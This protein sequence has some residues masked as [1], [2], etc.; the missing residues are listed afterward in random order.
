MKILEIRG[1]NAFGLKEFD[2]TPNGKSVIFK[3]RNGA[4]K[5]SL[6]KSIEACVGGTKDELKNISYLKGD[7]D[8]T[9]LLLVLGETDVREWELERSYDSEGRA[10]P[11]RFVLRRDGQKIEAPSRVL[12]QLVRA[13]HLLNPIRLFLASAR[14]RRDMFLR[15]IPASF[16]SEENFQKM[17]VAAYKKTGAIKE[18]AKPYDFTLV[19]RLVK[20][21]DPDFE[22]MHAL[23]ICSKLKKQVETLRTETGAMRDQKRDLLNSVIG[24]AAP[25]VYDS[26]KHADAEMHADDAKVVEASVRETKD[27]LR[28]AQLALDSSE[29]AVKLMQE[30]L[31]EIQKRLTTELAVVAIKAGK[32]MEA[33]LAAD[34]IVSLKEMHYTTLD[35]WLPPD[36]SSDRSKS[37][38]E[39][40]NEPLNAFAVQRQ[41]VEDFETA[42]KKSKKVR[43][44]I[45]RADALYE[46]AA[47]ATKVFK[48]GLPELI[49]TNVDMPMPGITVNDDGILVDGVPIEQRS[50]GER[51]LFALQLAERALRDGDERLDTMLIDGIEQIDPEHMEIVESYARD[52]RI[53][54][55]MTKVDRGDLRMEGVDDAGT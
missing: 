16:E 30:Q 10:R 32:V 41:R 12:A 25:P 17:L 45:E 52:N 53:Q 34:F 3:G 55:I 54:L 51:L 9:E 33:Q 19:N 22:T 18:G 13:T 11:G 26:D 4:G 23:E 49:I 47:D 44:E 20:E 6:M 27:Q 2:F 48:D 46:S 39:Q 1:V 29:N 5:S 36:R 43:E 40:W 28:V 14:D 24:T 38:T 37:L 35:K 50:N 31:A 15:A 8:D 42:Q 7:G 21:L